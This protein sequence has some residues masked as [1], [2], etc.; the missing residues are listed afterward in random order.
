MCGCHPLFVTP[1]YIYNLFLDCTIAAICI[2]LGFF[3]FFI[4][5]SIFTSCINDTIGRV[6]PRFSPLDQ[7]RFVV[8]CACVSF[9]NVRSVGTLFICFVLYRAAV[10][11]VKLLV[12]L[13]FPT[14]ALII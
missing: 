5:I 10:E 2:C 8:V 6:R 3:G 12:R 4:F 13:Q 1:L 11:D 14:E 9:F 7:G